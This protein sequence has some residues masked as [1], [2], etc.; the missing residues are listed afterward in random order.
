MS[1]RRDGVKDEPGDSED[2]LENWDDEP[3]KVIKF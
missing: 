1:V 2:D 3:D